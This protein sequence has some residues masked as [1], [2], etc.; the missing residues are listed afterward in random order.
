[1]L[2]LAQNGTLS[3]HDLAQRA[4]LEWGRVSKTVGQL[5]AKGLI[6]RTPKPSDRRSVQISLTEKGSLVYGQVLPKVIAINRELLGVLSASQLEQLDV[7]LS[8]LQHRADESLSPDELPKS[9]R[10][11]G[12]RS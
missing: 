9:Q 1:M 8:L 10:R 4:Q 6:S 11:L 7:I 3:S 5:L 2:V 12:G